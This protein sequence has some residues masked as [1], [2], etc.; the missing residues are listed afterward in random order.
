MLNYTITR[1]ISCNLFTGKCAA[2]L[3]YVDCIHCLTAD[4]N[5]C[6]R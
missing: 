1:G 2:K 5:R 6:I 4:T 3:Q